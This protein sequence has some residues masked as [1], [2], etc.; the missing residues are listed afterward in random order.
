MHG[1]SGTP[2]KE[3][4]ELPLNWLLLFGGLEGEERTEMKGEREEKGEEV[5][6]E[7]EL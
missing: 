7:E 3:E 5:E 6:E 4:L 1:S 2:A